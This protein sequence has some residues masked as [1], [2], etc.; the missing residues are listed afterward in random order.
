MSGASERAAPGV[1]LVIMTSPARLPERVRLLQRTVAR[2]I[3][4]RLRD[5]AG[6]H[7]KAATCEV[8]VLDDQPACAGWPAISSQVAAAE[9]AGVNLRYVALPPSDDGRVNM[10]LKRNVGLLL[11][12]GEVAVFCDDDDWRSLDSV[13]AQLEALEAHGVDMCTVQVQHVCEID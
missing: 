7:G 6:D 3:G 11:S 10:R 1:S 12:Q 5:G 13:Q 2:A 8:L 4:Q 9:Q